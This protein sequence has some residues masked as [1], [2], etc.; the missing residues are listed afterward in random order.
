MTRFSYPWF[1][2]VR[3]NARA[4]RK[5]LSFSFCTSATKTGKERCLC[6]TR[7]GGMAY[8]LYKKLNYKILHAQTCNVRV[9]RTQFER[10]SIFQ[11]YQ[12][13][14]KRPHQIELLRWQSTRI[15]L[16]VYPPSDRARS[17]SPENKKTPRIGRDSG[18]NMSLS[19]SVLFGRRMVYK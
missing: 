14:T 3:A 11:V 10:N 13:T 12:A 4:P 17:C 7:L 5:F 15:K 16:M 6:F 19:I 1:S 18:K 8:I 2:A 9:S